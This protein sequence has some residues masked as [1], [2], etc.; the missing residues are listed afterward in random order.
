MKL[1]YVIE[2]VADMDRA[3]KFY[4][5]VLGLSPKVPL[6]QLERI[7]HLFLLRR[8]WCVPRGVAVVG[9]DLVV[10]VFILGQAGGGDKRA[11]GRERR[12]VDTRDADQDD[13]AQTR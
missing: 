8:T 13:R 1:N 3:V 6:I 2:F 12:V 9:A 5:D 11:R 7:L 10:I 4:R